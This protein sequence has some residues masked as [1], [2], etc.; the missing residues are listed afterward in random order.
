MLAKTIKRYQLAMLVGGAAV[1]IITIVFDFTNLDL[2]IA[3]AVY[4]PTSPS[5]FP[6]GD[7]MPWG[8][9]NANDNDFVY[10]LVAIA[11][12]LL[13]AGLSRPR[14]RPLAVY[15]LFI[16]V[17]DVVG[18][19]LI[20]NFLLKGETI[21]GFYIG[22][23]RPRPR[24]IALFGG[25][26]SFYPVWQPA[27]LDGLKI[28]DSSFPSGHVVTGSIF[29]VIF[30]AFNNTTFIAAMFGARPSERCWCSIS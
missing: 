2:A 8:W 5:R 12:F 4:S 11:L 15:A 20:V 1:G 29:I 30:L 17:A 19:A 7:T 27:F 21:D 14:F 6:I 10:I 22:W 3:S 25:I 18:P 23:S 26:E 28:S 24:E 9:F 16:I 13:I